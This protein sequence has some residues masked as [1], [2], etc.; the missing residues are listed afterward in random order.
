MLLIESSRRI[1]GLNVADHGD[2]E[3][4]WL[5]SNLGYF[6]QG[7]KYQLKDRRGTWRKRLIANG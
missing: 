5:N 4:G 1:L 3:M 7:A 2:T 6:V